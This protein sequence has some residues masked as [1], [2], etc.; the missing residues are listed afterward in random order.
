MIKADDDQKD[1]FR[2]QFQGDVVKHIDKIAADYILPDEGTLDFRDSYSGG[3]MEVLF[4][5]KSG[6]FWTGLTGN[7]IKVY[8]RSKADLTNKLVPVKL[9]MTYRDGILGEIL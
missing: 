6:G 5:Q 3:T 4:E 9:T 2:R 1:K 7:Y 8:T